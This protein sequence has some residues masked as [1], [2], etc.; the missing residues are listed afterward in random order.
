MQE[1]KNQEKNTIRCLGGG[2]IHPD[3]LVSRPDK[4]QIFFKNKRKPKTKKEGSC[5]AKYG[6][7]LER[8]NEIK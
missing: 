7:M 8:T 1:I 6:M 3:P 2:T 5:L 4:N